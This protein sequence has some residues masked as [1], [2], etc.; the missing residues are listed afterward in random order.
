VKKDPY[1]ELYFRQAKIQELYF[2]R[3]KYASF[4]LQLAPFIRMIGLNGSVARGEAGAGSD[5]DFII[6]TKPGRIWTCRFFS[7][8]LMFVIGLKRSEKKISGRICLNLYQTEEKL[9]LTVKNSLL[10]RSHSFTQC[11]WQEKDQFSRFVRQNGWIRDFSYGFQSKGYSIKNNEKIVRNILR[12]FRVINEFIFEL[13][14]ND[15]GERQ[16]GIY[17]SRRILRDPRTKNA[18]P[19]EIHISDSELRFHPKK[20]S[21]D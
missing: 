2:R 15:W 5:I 6:I 11:L 14:F 12:I 9:E 13:C 17:Q 19:G 10:A 7:L 20:L 21:I 16:L 4:V 1:Q 3:A 18:K 8:L